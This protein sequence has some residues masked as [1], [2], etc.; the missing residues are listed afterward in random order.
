MK[1]KCDKCIHRNVC[2]ILVNIETDYYARMGIGYNTE[3]CKHYLEH[4]VT[5]N[6]TATYEATLKVQITHE[7]DNIENLKTDRQ[8]AE[9]LAHMI[10]D[11]ASHAGGVACY[12][13]L[14]S[15]IDVH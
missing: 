1:R 8:F 15:K 5:M 3:T 12:E 7:I 13:I 9:D 6:K 11:E 2:N 10:C 14:E 4:Y